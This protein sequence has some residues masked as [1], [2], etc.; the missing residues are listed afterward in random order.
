M[1]FGAEDDAKQPDFQ[2]E[3]QPL[4]T[5]NVNNFKPYFIKKIIQNMKEVFFSPTVSELNS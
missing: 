2:S 4:Q 3:V 5:N 1:I